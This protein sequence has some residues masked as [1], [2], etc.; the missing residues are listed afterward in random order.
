MKKLTAIFAATFTLSGCAT[1]QPARMAQPVALGAVQAIPVTGIGGGRSGAFAAGPYSGSFSRSD[2]RLAFFDDLFE[3]RSGHVDFSLTGPEID[4]AI[5]ARCRMRERMVTIGVISFKP[6]RMA[7]GCGFTH[8]GRAISARFEIQE[9]RKGLAGAMMR[10]ERRGEIALDRVILQIRSV[11]DLQGSPL[12]MG[13]PIGYVFEDG[14][15]AIGS[16]EING[17][18]VVRIAPGTDEATRRAVIAASMAL[19][20][21]WDPAASALGR[22]AN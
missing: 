13:T 14:G 1:I 20:L 21:F 17:R 3:R 10:Q 19:G 9:A 6:Q 7:F 2:D 8:Q 12:Q 5:D 18:P 11:H 22:E 16:V 4:G 15:V